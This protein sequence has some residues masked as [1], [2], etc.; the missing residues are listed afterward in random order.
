MSVFVNEQKVGAAAGA[1]VMAE[2]ANNTDL[3]NQIITSLVNA[4]VDA[5][6]KHGPEVL[7][8]VIAKLP[9]LVQAIHDAFAHKDTVKPA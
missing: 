2:L 9:E 4:L 6:I 5:A 7:D 3:R 8:M 1:Q